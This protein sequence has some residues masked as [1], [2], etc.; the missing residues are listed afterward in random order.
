[1]KKRRD[2]EEEKYDKKTYAYVGAALAAA[3]AALFTLAFF[4]L[5]IYGVIAAIICETAALAFERIQR[6]KND[7]KALIALRIT[8]Y[9]LLAAFG[10]FFIGG[11]IWAQ[12]VK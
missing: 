5:K 6:G 7:F 12:T 3:G 2:E 11:F 1:M 4:V 10:A 8:A 9:V